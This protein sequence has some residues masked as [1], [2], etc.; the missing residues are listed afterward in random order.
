MVPKYHLLKSEVF[1]DMFSTAQE[2][3]S[4]GSS[5]DRPIVLGGVSAA[6]FE[7]L[8]NVLYAPRFSS[9]EPDLDPHFIPAFRLARKW[10]FKD[11]EGLLL[12]HLEEQLGDI[13]KIIFA[14]EFDLKEWIISSHVKLCERAEPLTSKEAEKLGVQSVLLLSRLREEKAYQ[15]RQVPRPTVEWICA[16]CLGYEQKCGGATWQCYQCR[17]NG[18]HVLRRT[19]Q[20]AL[21]TDKDT[22]QKVEQWIQSGGEFPEQISQ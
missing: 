16:P 19:S 1:S 13:D 22:K 5:A 21:P 20:V 2:D 3:L 12:H 17:A 7:S 18:L 9:S 14:R 4:E 10:S 8:L 15:V 11:F 6:D